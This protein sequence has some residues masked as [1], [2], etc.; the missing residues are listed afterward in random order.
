M[1]VKLRES[2][3]KKREKKVKLPANVDDDDESTESDGAKSDV[4]DL[5]FSKLKKKKKGVK[6][7][8]SAS[9][10]VEE[11]RSTSKAEIDHQDTLDTIEYENRE[12]NAVNTDSEYKE[13]HPLSYS[14]MFSF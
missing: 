10:L 13:A 8:T 4:D 14:L 12:E 2:F 7:Q 11:A 3:L 1:A 6:V 5:D 9:D